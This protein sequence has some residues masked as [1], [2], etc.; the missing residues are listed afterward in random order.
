MRITLKKKGQQSDRDPLVLMIEDPRDMDKEPKEKKFSKIIKTVTVGDSF[1]VADLCPQANEEE[2]LALGHAILAKYK[3]LFTM[4]GYEA[5]SKKS[6]LD[7][8][9]A[10][11][12]KL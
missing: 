12:V 9:M 10:P 11:E 1:N 7:K 6:Y 2:V 8:A 5:K 3:G 4:D